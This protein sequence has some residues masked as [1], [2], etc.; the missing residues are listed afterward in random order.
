MPGFDRTA[1]QGAGPVSGDLGCCGS[2]AVV[3]SIIQ[4]HEFEA[5]MDS[6]TGIGEVVG[7]FT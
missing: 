7:A 6:N 4:P 1:T 3:G 5:H 2:I